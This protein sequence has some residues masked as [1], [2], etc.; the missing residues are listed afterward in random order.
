MRRSFTCEAVQ[1][2]GT[3][4]S[5]SQLEGPHGLADQ[6]VWMEIAHFRYDGGDVRP[7]LLARFDQ[8]QADR[9]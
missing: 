9:R 7:R 6:A 8:R 5:A 1:P 3:G 2:H 4:G